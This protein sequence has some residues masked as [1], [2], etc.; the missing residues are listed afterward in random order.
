YKNVGHDTY[1]AGS[2]VNLNANNPN[3]WTYAPDLDSRPFNH[4]D[5]WDLQGR[6]TAQATQKLKVGFSW[7]ETRTCF[8]SSSINATTA[9]EAAL[10]RP[11]PTLRNVMGDWTMPLTN[12]VL[13][14]GSFVRRIQDQARR[15]PPDTHPDMISVT[16]QSLG[17]L[18]Y[19][20][21]RASGG[22]PPL[23]ETVFKTLFIR[24]AVSYI[25]GAHAF[26]AGFT[27]G[28]ALEDDEYHYGTQ[29]VSYRFNNGIPNQITLY[30][31][32]VGTVMNYDWNTE[33]GAF[34]Q[35]RWTIGRL[36]ATYGLRYDYY[37]TSF[38]EQTVGPTALLP[39]RN[40][41]IPAS[42]GVS[43][44]DL[45][46]KTGAAYDLFGTG[47]TALKVSLNKYV[48]G[49]G[50]SGEFGRPLN[51]INRLVNVTTRNWTD[52]NRNFTPDCDLINPAANGECAAMANRNFGQS[53]T[54]GS[55]VYDPDVLSGWGI[56]GYN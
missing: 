31:Y 46:P 50:N 30:A 29:P 9:P 36:T 12:R 6:V 56:R 5:S 11:T 42:P 1:P 25:T 54:A 15:V 2:Y 4:L 47:K 21:V 32:P 37:K 35:D 27:I 39:N 52:G 10:Y 7:Q 44:H 22:N 28:S 41:T 33:S 18:V 3:A 55:A 45:T 51:P 53:S 13:I 19:R 34:V 16:E 49:Q 40:I 17:N 8:C 38:P 23:R 20:T 48:A 24:S 26:K 14:D 43:W